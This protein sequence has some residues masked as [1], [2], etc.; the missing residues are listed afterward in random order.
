MPS[1]MS[2]VVKGKGEVILFL[3]GWGQNKEM[4]LPLIE[5]LK[6]KYKCVIIDMPGFGKTDFNGCETIGSYTK[7][8]RTFLEKEKLLPKYIVGHSF[9]GKIAIEY[10]LNHKDLKKIVLIASP[11][12]KPDRRIGYYYKVYKY[13]LLKKIFKNKKFNLGSEDYKNCPN[14]M[15]KFFNQVVNM[16]YNNQVSNI[17]IPTL[18]IWS[19]KD[20][21]VPL[22]KGKKLFK[23]IKNS[24]L[25][26]L[27]GTHFAY[28]ENIDFTRLIIQKFFRE[29]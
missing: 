7:K 21:K 19:D 9:G 22:K 27:K 18:L 20:K 11:I 17:D 12:L 8:I 16:H 5:M 10:Y 6:N 4:M 2:C 24:K 28:L 1:D 3:H 13:K 29:E 26:V 15:K 23:M 25:Y 14:G